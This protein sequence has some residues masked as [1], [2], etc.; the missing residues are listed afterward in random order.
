M[1]PRLVLS[2]RLARSVLCTQSDERLVELARAGSEPAFE[3]LVARHRRDLV[4]VCERILGDGDAEEAVQEALLRAHA[5]VIRG[6]RVQSA[7]PW[8]RRIAHNAALNLLRARVSRARAT[9]EHSSLCAGYDDDA[10]EWRLELTELLS[11][12]NSLPARQREAIVMR[13]F[14]GR[15]YGEIAQ[16]LGTSRGAVRQL[17]HRAR[18]AVRDRLAA[19]LPW[20]AAFRWAMTSSGATGARVGAL[21]DTCATGAKM[22]AALLP[23]AAIGAGG[24]PPAVPP[25][26]FSPP[27]PRRAAAVARPRPAHPVRVVVAVA[28][29]PTRAAAVATRPAA[30]APRIS[31]TP[32]PAATPNR[33]T[34]TPQPAAPNIVGPR[35]DP[36]E[37]LTSEDPGSGP[38]GVRQ[39][40]E[41]H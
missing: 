26:H 19:L 20:N 10:A 39:A 6:D 17:L 8:L 33:P 11:A 35:P 28:A 40:A 1:N 16:R 22:C 9:H 15:G 24:L 2:A 37:E 7:G 3:A 27:R 36:R 14:E 25:H 31:S 23:V 12:L 30:A 41:G 4:G 13:E 32:T 29:V 21:V 18:A 34:S 38:R 5:A